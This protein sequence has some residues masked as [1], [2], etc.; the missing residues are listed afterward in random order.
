MN[1]NLGWS[2]T[3]ISLYF[4]LDLHTDGCLLIPLKG[5]NDSDVCIQSLQPAL[6][7]APYLV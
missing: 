5:F 3:K 2:V 4:S 1:H 6:L 7:F